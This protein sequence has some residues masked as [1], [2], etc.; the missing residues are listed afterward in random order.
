MGRDPPGAEYGVAAA[1]SGLRARSR[2]R[3]GKPGLGEP[4]SAAWPRQQ[5]R[6]SE[7]RSG[8]RAGPAAVL[9]CS[10]SR[11]RVAPRGRGG[12]PD[13]PCPFEGRGCRRVLAVSFSVPAPSLCPVT[14]LREERSPP[15]PARRRWVSARGRGGRPGLATG[16]AQVLPRGRAGAGGAVYPGETILAVL[17]SRWQLREA[18]LC[19]RDPRLLQPKMLL[20]PGRGNQDQPLSVFGAAKASGRTGWAVGCDLSLLHSSL[21]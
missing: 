12:L 10:V 8:V 11:S 3:P 4:P 17:R 7:L 16:S 2:Y 20:H 15:S 9:G 6:W 18:Q 5:A 19:W 13:S 14:R 21:L 1:P